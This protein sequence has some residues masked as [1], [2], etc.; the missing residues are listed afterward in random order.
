VNE[1]YAAQE[2]FLENGSVAGAIHGDK[3]GIAESAQC[4]RR[5]GGGSKR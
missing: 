5:G 4:A 3:S 2:E 1:K